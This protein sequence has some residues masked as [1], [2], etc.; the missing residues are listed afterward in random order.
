MRFTKGEIMQ[1]IIKLSNLYEEYHAGL[2]EKKD[3]EGAIFK[4]IKEEFRFLPGL[5]YEDI[6]DFISWLYLRLKRAIDSY[7][8][9]GSSFEIY[10]RTLVRLAAKEFRYR[11]AHNYS[12]ESA[13]WITQIPDMHTCEASP[14]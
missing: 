8:D 2:L 6:D 10:I 3:L 5:S 9:K 11:Q 7:K 4:T 13:A 12:A 14:E 1:N